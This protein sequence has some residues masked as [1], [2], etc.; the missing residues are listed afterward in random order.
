MEM[1]FI[2]HNEPPLS[3]QSYL[4][5]LCKRYINIHKLKWSHA[6]SVRFAGVSFI[7]VHVCLLNVWVVLTWF[8][9][10]LRFLSK[11]TD[12]HY[13]LH[14]SLNIRRTIS[15]LSIHGML[16]NH[17]PSIQSQAHRYSNRKLNEL[18]RSLTFS[19]FTIHNRIGHIVRQNRTLF[20]LDERPLRWSEQMANPSSMVLWCSLVSNDPLWIS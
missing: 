17:V 6:V 15:F 19:I 5:R 16:L 3:C 7:C 10:R 20:Q 2:N 12:L 18:D 11:T 1:A 8:W 13:V 4:Y 9:F 14:C